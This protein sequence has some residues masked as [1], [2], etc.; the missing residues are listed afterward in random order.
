MTKAHVARRKRGGHWWNEVGG[1]RFCRKCPLTACRVG[2]AIQ[3]RWPD[4]RTQLGG[5]VPK[6]ERNG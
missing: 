2:N 5:K 3:Y 1:V 4:G 6:C